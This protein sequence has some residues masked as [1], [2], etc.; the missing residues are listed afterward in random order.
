MELVSHTAIN[1]D[2]GDILDFEYIVIGMSKCGTTSLQDSLDQAGM[3]CIKFHSDFTLERVFKHGA[4]TTKQLVPDTKAIFVPYRNPIDRKVSQFYFYGKG[5]TN[6]ETAVHDLRLFCLG[7]YALFNVGDQTEIK[8]ELVYQNIREAT[9]I[10]V[11]DHD[12]NKELGFT[13][14]EENGYRLIPF[15]IEKI[16]NLGEF[17]GIEILRRRVSEKHHMRKVVRNNLFFT[18]E[19]LDRIYSSRYVQHFYTAEQIEEFKLW[20]K[21]L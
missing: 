1:T 4:P 3:P 6:K 10:N 16:D 7:D 11:L 21:E 13:V 19:E 9:G 20:E 8:E 17:L 15:V 14:I 18:D 5:W 2:V 12:F